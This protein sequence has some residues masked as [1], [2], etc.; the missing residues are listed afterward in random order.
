MNR[1]PNDWPAP[2]GAIDLEVH[3]LA[4]ASS[5][6]EWWYLNGH[7]EAQ[8]GRAFSLFASF[9]RYRLDEDDPSGK[10][11][12]H[13]LT[14]ALIDLDGQ[15]YW[16]ES[17]LDPCTPDQ[18]LRRLDRPGEVR[19]ELLRE[20]MRE[21]FEA[22]QVPL[23]DRLLPEDGVV[24]QGRLE[25]DFGGR[26]LTKLGPGRYELEL[27]SEDGQTGFEV[28]FEMQKDVVRHGD[29]GV[30]RGVEREE[31]FYYFC[32]R[33]EVTGELLVQGE[34]LA[35][36]S[37]SGWYD[38][39]FGRELARDG[40]DA[41]ESLWVGW[42]WLS[43]QLDNGWELSAYDLFAEDESDSR[44]HWLILIDP[45][46]RRQAFETFRFEARG[47][48]TSSYTFNTY[49]VRWR[50]VCEEA[51]LDLLVDPPF[52]HQEFA[53][54]LSR[55]GFWE[56]RVDVAGTLGE[57]EVTGRGL[58]ERRGPDPVERL[59]DFFEAVGEQTRRA[60][61]ELVPREPTAAQLTRIL[62]DGAGS[63]ARFLRG[64]DPAQV[65]RVALDPI[66]D[67]VDRGGKA[68][69]SYGLLACCDLVGGDSQ[70]FMSWLAVPELLHTGSL[71][72]DDV[73]DGSDVRRGGPP[74]HAL[75]GRPLA[76]NAGNLCYFLGQLLDYDAPLTESQRLQVYQWYF[77]GL[78]AGHIGQSLDIDGVGHQARRAVE[79]G[80]SEELEQ[81]VLAIHRLKSAAPVGAIGRMGALLGGAEAELVEAVGAYLEQLGLAFQ[82]IDD[83]LN[84][85][86]FER[87][88]KDH[89]EDLAH[90]KVT[91]PVARA[92]GHLD[93]PGR[94]WLW[95]TLQ[96]QPQD[97]DVI[98]QMIERI[99]QTGALE[100]ADAEAREL[101]ESAWAELAPRVPDSQVKI[102][103]RAFGWF[104]LDRQY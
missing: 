33:C 96:S 8:G 82:I 31:M 49:P 92:L 98:A 3:D 85:R 88:L 69:R 27:V 37:G 57:V 81:A 46:G 104:V 70:P 64:V 45:E 44:G 38:H 93:E 60:I 91:Y 18:A 77:E 36:E 75:H 99:E 26:R 21:I 1:Y 87:D 71:I 40:E 52:E 28:V 25:L 30:V 6:L 17:L 43:A 72:V 9:F 53:T 47:E 2:T 35:I 12:A 19:D 39:E 7:V 89:G 20:A 41:E 4:H 61:A 78:R 24:A 66:R 94:R 54:M 76:I 83:V 14:W 68:W 50:L 29:R 32:P 16:P 56:G 59:R 48:W 62:G 102:K 10:S 5:A 101:V 86:G 63:G 90:G 11:H 55:P 74:S 15:R 58:V 51:G 65:G 67:I 103:L 97:P 79:S 23:P 22:G 95:E 42:N 73:Q 34:R 13:S 84:L 100:E 80:D